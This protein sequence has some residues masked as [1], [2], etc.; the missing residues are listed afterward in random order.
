MGCSDWDPRRV[1]LNGFLRVTMA[2]G[3]IL[4]S[5][6]I[7]LRTP[8]WQLEK[9]FEER[10][11]EKWIKMRKNLAEICFVGSDW[12]TSDVE[13]VFLDRNRLG[14]NIEFWSNFPPNPGLA[15][16]EGF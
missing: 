7:S 10:I 9:V 1:M 11:F 2:L 3:T 16:R 14:N 4:N 8:V 15:V 13:C 12:D 6:Q 5:G